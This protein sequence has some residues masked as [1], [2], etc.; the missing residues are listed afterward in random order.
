MAPP[1]HLFHSRQQEGD[2]FGQNRRNFRLWGKSG[3]ID[4]AIGILR[5]RGRPSF[6]RHMRLICKGG[7][8][9]WRRPTILGHSG[10][11]RA[12]IL[13]KI[14]EICD[15]GGGF[16]SYS[17]LDWY[18]SIPRPPEFTSCWNCDTAAGEYRFRSSINPTS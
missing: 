10:K 11:R 15:F 2:N 13:A 5:R 16:G 6:R 12:V 4:I 1:G 14:A 17:Y 9:L 8:Q 18:I 7:G 3:P